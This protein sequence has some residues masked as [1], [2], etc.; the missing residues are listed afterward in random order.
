MARTKSEI[1]KVVHEEAEKSR[2]DLKIVLSA[3]GGEQFK[4]IQDAEH[5]VLKR[6]NSQRAKKT[7]ELRK[8]RLEQYISIRHIHQEDTTY[9]CLHLPKTTENKAQYAVSTETQY[10]VFKIW[11]EYNILEDIKRG[12]LDNSTSN[13]LIPLDSWTSRLLVYEL[14]LSELQK[15]IY[16]GTHYEDV[17]DHIAKVLKMV[18]LIYVSRVDSHQLRMKVFPISLADDAKEWW[19]SYGD[20]KITTWE[21]LVEKFLCRFYPKSYDREDEMLDEGENWGIDPLEFLSNINTSFKYHK[22]V[23]GR[24]QKVIFHAWMNG[25]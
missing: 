14:P 5:Q 21:E 3:E 12:D 20:E 22:K 6:E 7:T 9:P 8:K 10:T 13:I 11:N 15:N 18:D 4:K 2:I 25:N 16:H 23:D 1:I 17:V 19:I 24:T